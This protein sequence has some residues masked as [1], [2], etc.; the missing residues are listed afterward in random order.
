MKRFFWNIP[1]ACVTIL[2]SWL[3]WSSG[4]KDEAAVVFV[5]G[6]LS[7]WVII[8]IS[9]LFQIKRRNRAGKIIFIKRFSKTPL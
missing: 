2:F 8:T 3:N 5:A 9:F 1:T 4:Q 7:V 6:G